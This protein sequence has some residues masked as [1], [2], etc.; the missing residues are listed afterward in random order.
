MIVPSEIW[1]IWIGMWIVHIMLTCAKALLG[2]F[3]WQPSRWQGNM[4]ASMKSYRNLIKLGVTTLML[5]PGKKIKVVCFR[6]TQL[7]F[8]SSKYL[9]SSLYP[10]RAAHLELLL[11]ALPQDILSV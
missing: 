1:I 7:L 4:V 9:L 11:L 5:R 10:L 2:K 6:R 8:I 3:N